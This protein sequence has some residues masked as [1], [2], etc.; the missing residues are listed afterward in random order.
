HLTETTMFTQLGQ[1][2]GTIEYMSPEQAKLNQLDIDTRTDIYSL[3]VL[4]YELLTGE[5]PFD[6]QRLRSPAFDTMLRIHREEEAPK[7]STRLSSSESLP[8][9]AANR[10]LEPKKLTTVVSGE[11]DWIVMKA[12]D[13]DRGR[14]YETAGGLVMDI[15][16]YLRDE[17]I[18]ARPASSTYRF[19]KL[20]KRNR[21]AFAAAAARITALLLGG[22]A[23]TW[24]AIR[25]T[26]SEH[27]QVRLR[28]DAD[29]ARKQ[30]EA[31]EQTA[32]TEAAKSTQVAAF[33]QDMLGAVGPSVAL[34]R[35]T[36]LLREILEKTAKRL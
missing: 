27:E 5:T 19:R 30:A 26:R 10:Q 7:P 15:D 9:S 4:L 34:G 14:R 29:R 18:T 28:V 17:P 24:Q 33:L 13:K 1:V 22:I 36:E 3:G 16:R 25:A 23:S 11:L 35:D 12:L 8:S 20:V 21:L 31:D 32:K 6:R 2:V